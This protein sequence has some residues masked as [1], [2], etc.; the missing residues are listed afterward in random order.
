[1]EKKYKTYAEILRNIWNVS[2]IN[3]IFSLEISLIT[4]FN[5]TN[6]GHELSK[7]LPDMSSFLS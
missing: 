1:M 2:L 3:R 5:I 7:T 6:T 4:D